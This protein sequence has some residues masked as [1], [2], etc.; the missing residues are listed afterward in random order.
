MNSSQRRQ[1]RRGYPHV[2]Q[3]NANPM[4]RY[5]HHDHK[6]AEAQAWCRKQ[7]GKGKFRA[8]T[9]WDRTEFKFI[10]EKDA[11]HFALKWA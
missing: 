4:E 9:D 1:A 6:V 3:I 7:F 10:R 2:V 5:F 11:V 8:H